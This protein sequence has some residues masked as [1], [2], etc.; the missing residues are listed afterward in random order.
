MTKNTKPTMLVVRAFPR[1]AEFKYYLSFKALNVVLV[2]AR[3][4]LHRTISEELPKNARSVLR[5][6][7]YYLLF[8]PIKLITGV[9][10]H[11]S[12]VVFR[13]IVDLIKGSDIV[14]ISDLY[15][16][17]GYHAARIAKQHNKRIVAVV[18][19][20]RAHHIATRIPPYSFLVRYLARTVDLFILRSKKGYEFTDSIGIPRAKTVVI[21]Q[22]INLA[23]FKPQKS[24]LKGDIRFLY[25]GQI[26]KEKG[27]VELLRAF[28]ELQTK[29]SNVQLDVIGSGPH[30]A[31]LKRTYESDTVVFHGFMRNTLTADYYNKAHVFVSPSTSGKFG[32][33]VL[34]EERFSY[35]LMEAQA[36]GCA[37]IATR[38]GGIP[39]EIGSENILVDQGDWKGLAEAME[40]LARNP[41]TIKRLGSY[42][43]SRALANFDLKKQAHLMEEKLLDLV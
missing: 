37:I 38:C 18:W 34:Y 9:A 35:T 4:K 21:Y 10:T 20:N 17:Y 13:D 36:A 25:V 8:D 42:S 33:L 12:W 43:R 15:F 2:G 3:K 16:F 29:C 39:E 24:Y 30:L 11:R 7:K 5:S 23:R 40:G 27:V 26:S 6:T 28:K 41:Q 31:K 22:G 32:P 14:N 19:E 1:Y